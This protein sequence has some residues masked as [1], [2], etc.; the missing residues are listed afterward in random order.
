MACAAIIESCADKL[1][2]RFECPGLREDLISCGRL[3]V[4]EQAAVY[5]PDSDASV[6]TYLYPF[7]LGAMR[8]ELEQSLFS[9]SF[10]KRGFKKQIEEKGLTFVALDEVF[11]DA[12][13]G[14]WSLDPAS[15]VDVE[16]AVFAKIYL[17][18]LRKEFEQCSFKDKEILGGLFGAFGYEEQPPEELAFTFQMTESAVL[19][20]KEKALARL[21]GVCLNGELGV[22]REVRKMMRA[23]S[24]GQKAP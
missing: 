5:R 20:A 4:L 15:P 8:R 19:K 10:S 3:A 13:G 6:T 12:E 22:W 1:C 14:E 21:R 18:L 2:F 9:M 16:R 23:A 24:R 7:I 17:E 11:E